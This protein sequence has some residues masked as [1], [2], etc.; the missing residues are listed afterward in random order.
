[1]PGSIHS[2]LTKGCH[3]LIK[4]GAKLAETADDI[5]EELKLPARERRRA[6]AARRRAR[7][8][9]CSRSSASIR[10]TSTRSPR[11]AASSA[12]ALAALLTQWEIEGLVEALPGG[13]Y[14]RVR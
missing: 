13:R 3:S 6:G 14:Q 5:L 7:R 10:A 12:D 2:P 1:M 11:A 8:T 4:Q 9:P